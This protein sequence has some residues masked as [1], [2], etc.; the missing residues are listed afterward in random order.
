MVSTPKTVTRKLS[1]SSAQKPTGKVN[2]RKLRLGEGETNSLVSAICTPQRVTRF[3]LRNGLMVPPAAPTPLR[4][5][6]TT[7]K[8][9][10]E[11]QVK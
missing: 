11:I 10:T 4:Q 7:G 6:Q 2:H 1:A 8:R 3:S 5:R 9:R